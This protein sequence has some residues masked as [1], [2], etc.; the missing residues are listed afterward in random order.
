MNDGSLKMPNPR[1][2]VSVC[3][4]TVVR[5]CGAGSGVS[6]AVWARA[7]GAARSATIATAADLLRMAASV[8]RTP[9]PLNDCWR[10]GCSRGLLK[11]FVRLCLL[12]FP[13]LGFPS[14]RV[15]QR[16][17]V[18]KCPREFRHHRLI[19]HDDADFAALVQLELAKTLTSKKG[20]TMISDNRARVQALARVFLVREIVSSLR[21]LADDADIHTG[22]DVL[23]ERFEDGCIADLGIINEQL[24]LGLAHVFSED[25]ARIFRTDDELA[26]RRVVWLARRI[27][28]EEFQCLLNV[29]SLA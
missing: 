26:W 1:S 13:Q 24:L 22:L 8:A 15:G 9:P 21:D 4:G 29:G 28:L 6:L 18:L 7:N 16:P 25:A 11:G 19:F 5:V 14:A 23:P 27:R 10:R 17:V 2:A 20:V 3:A 12:F